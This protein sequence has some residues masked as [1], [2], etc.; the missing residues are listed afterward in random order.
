[1]IFP[2]RTVSSLESAAALVFDNVHFRGEVADEQDRQWYFQLPNQDC[3]HPIEDE[4]SHAV[5]D[6]AIA[7]FAAYT[8]HNRFVS[9][10]QVAPFVSS[11]AASSSNA[12]VPGSGVSAFAVVDFTVF[13][14]CSRNLGRMNSEQA[15]DFFLN[16]HLGNQ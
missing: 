7:N 9:R 16:Q 8:E 6:N 11:S 3:E 10:E 2:F 13:S 15:L 5:S 4:D 12:L 1:M 14:A